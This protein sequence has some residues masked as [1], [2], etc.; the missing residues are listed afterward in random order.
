MIKKILLSILTFQCVAGA[1]FAD[2]SQLLYPQGKQTHIFVN[3]RILAKVN[4]NAI[5]V[6][7]VMK[8]MDMLFY[9][10]FPQYADLVEARYQY[11]QINWKHVLKEMVEKELLMADAQESKME[12]SNGDIRQEMETFFG[13]NIIANLE[14]AG[15]TYDEAWKMMKEDLTIQRMMTGRVTAKAIRTVTPS[16]IRAAYEEY[17]K[18]NAR[19]NAWRYQVITLRGED[20]TASAEAANYSHRLLT[21]DNLPI[22]EL[23]TKLQEHSLIGEKTSFTISEEFFLTEKEISEAHKNTLSSLKPNSFSIPI[24]QQSRANNAMVFRIFYL[25]EKVPGGNPPFHEV[26]NKLKN[27]L[28]EK[29]IEKETIA[30]I[31]KLREHYDLQKN[32]PDRMFPEDLQPF[33]LK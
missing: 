22:A 3:N 8:K 30:Y 6:I 4:G 17:A 29:A 21:E 33:A 5:S 11:Y 23:K 13:P 16:D 15:L 2:N 25:K 10:Q 31:D 28:I 18:E 19:Q 9:R 12:I 7:D 20:Q 27:M 32:S 24:A 1:A 14:K 26:E